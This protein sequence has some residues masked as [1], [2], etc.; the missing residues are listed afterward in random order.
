M[1]TQDVMFNRHRPS[2]SPSRPGYIE[3]S[4][5]LRA[6]GPP[7]SCEEVGMPQNLDLIP[8]SGSAAF[9]QNRSIH[10]R[11]CMLTWSRKL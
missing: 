9:T 8:R 10:L 2:P 4:V 11:P 6:T 1:D 3:A 7:C 5:I